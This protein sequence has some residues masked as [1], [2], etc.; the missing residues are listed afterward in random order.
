[1]DRE[2]RIPPWKQEYF[3]QIAYGGGLKL[4]PTLQMANRIADWLFAFSSNW[5]P[6]RADFERSFDR[7]DV[8]VSAMSLR[9]DRDEWRPRCSVARDEKEPA[10]AR[11]TF[12]ETV[13]RWL[14]DRIYR[15]ERGEIDEPLCGV[16]NNCDLDE[17]VIYER[18]RAWNPVKPA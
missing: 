3:T 18:M 16:F 7:F 5:V 17:K 9:S 2:L 1:M 4:S 6:R 14:I 15:S 12:E 13:E 11:A 8:L 10:T